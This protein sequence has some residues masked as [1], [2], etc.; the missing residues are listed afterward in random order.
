MD[1][2]AA[3]SISVLAQSLL[4]AS[5]IESIGVVYYDDRTKRRYT[6]FRHRYAIELRSE[7]RLG[8]TRPGDARKGAI[9]FTLRPTSFQ[10][11]RRC[12]RRPYAGAP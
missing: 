2:Q 8:Q 12:G 10:S 9:A 4:Q 5:V 11:V 7:A 3:R 1:Q 6:S